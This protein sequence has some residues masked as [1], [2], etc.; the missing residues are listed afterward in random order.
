MKWCSSVVALL[1]MCWSLPAVAEGEYPKDL[2][3]DASLLPVP[4][5]VDDNVKILKE[6]LEESYSPALE[7]LL[8]IQY[9]ARHESSEA[10]KLCRNA[11]DSAVTMEPYYCMAMLA[12]YAG[13][14]KD[15]EDWLLQARE[16]AP[17]RA[18]TWLLEAN[19][20]SRGGDPAKVVAVIERGRKQAV[21]Y[22]AEYWDWELLRLLETM[23]DLEGALQVAGKLLHR[24]PSDPRIYHKTALLLWK[25]GDL[26]Q[27]VRMELACLARA[28]W[29]EE[30][31]TS[32]L[33]LL[34]AQGRLEEFVAYEQQ[35]IA[36]PQLRD[37]AARIRERSVRVH[38]NMFNRETEAV[39]ARYGLRNEARE[40]EKADPATAGAMLRELGNLARKHGR[41]ESALGWLKHAERL[42]P[43]DPEVRLSLGQALL[44]SG[45]YDAAVE[46]L[47][48]QSREGNPEACLVAAQALLAKSAPSTCIDVANRGLARRPDD[49]ELLRVLSTC[50]F[51]VGR[52]Q[53]ALEAIEK[54]LGTDPQDRQAQISRV[55]W[56]RPKDPTTAIDLLWQLYWQD[57]W[58]Y[59][60]CVKG[61]GWSRESGK[62]VLEARW[63]AACMGFMPPF[64]VDRRNEFIERIRFLESSDRNVKKLGLLSALCEKDG[65]YCEGRLGLTEQL[66]SGKVPEL[67]S[68][69]AAAD[70][71]APVVLEV[72]DSAAGKTE[73]L[74]LSAKGFEGLELKEKLKYYYLSRATIAALPLLYVQNHPLALPLTRLMEDLATGKK[75]KPRVK[76]AAGAYLK[77]LWA[78]HGP[79]DAATG[80]KIPP[81]ELSAEAVLEGMRALTAEGRKL[82]YLEGADEQEK[83]AGIEAFLFD[84]GVDAVLNSGPLAKDPVKDSASGIYARELSA[85]DISAAEAERPRPVNVRYDFDA[86]TVGAKPV[87]MNAAWKNGAYISNTV[88]FLRKA[89][90]FCQDQ[91]ESTAIEALAAYLERGDASDLQAWQAAARAFSSRGWQFGFTDVGRDP[92]L[93]TG[94]FEALVSIP[95]S[96]EG[97]L[98]RF[99]AAF[100]G[101]MPP[102]LKDQRAAAVG[103][104]ERTLLSGVF[105]ANTAC[106]KGTSVSE[107]GV[108]DSCTTILHGLPEGIM[109]AGAVDPE[110]VLPEY[111]L[112]VQKRA[113]PARQWFRYLV[114][115]FRAAIPR[116]LPP[117]REPVAVWRA[118]VSAEKEA[119]IAA[120]YFMS[121]PRLVQVGAFPARIHEQVLKAAYVMY[122]LACPDPGRAARFVGNA[123]ASAHAELCSSMLAPEGTGGSVNVLSRNGRSFVSITDLWGVREKLAAAGA[124]L[125]GRRASEAQGHKAKA[126]GNKEKPQAAS[127]AGGAV[128]TAPVQSAMYRA[129]TG[130]RVALVYPRLGLVKNAEG[131]VVDVVPALD[132]DFTAQQSRFSRLR[133]S[134]SEE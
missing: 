1:L 30:A 95:V 64:V 55:E 114:E 13:Q 48:G 124:E 78:N 129:G 69:G 74:R 134:L 47:E 132:E 38:E 31:A 57:P 15:A 33:D 17:E 56:Y 28:P 113:V 94:G 116:P 65:V 49:K 103:L 105:E 97:V 86:A 35:F 2:M 81:A 4:G 22:S 96:T 66:D 83:L 3:L 109:P 123:A 54:I 128:G 107:S 126:P 59:R 18:E 131:Q 72:F 37:F 63:M 85:S 67:E 14:Q 130:S 90:G 61:A 51:M 102:W 39:I 75:V 60:I 7:A 101:T 79:Y 125:V 53:D 36:S 44:D 29:F 12:Y 110:S 82:G 77:I 25:K 88:Y 27:A 121:D 91:R 9:L 42:L 117:Q 80:L 111:R 115:Y 119:Q 24:T 21:S 92:L 70:G 104:F 8:G 99:N 45:L 93:E 11:V 46:K 43:Q 41:M 23:G 34:E 100:A 112:M 76:K 68:E 118:Q 50:L 10:A 62:P 26:E 19:A 73:V 87:V 127:G 106:R 120:L 6:R 32:L 40:L 71:T 98:E 20:A 5:F 89:I 58:D 84:P 122:F 108:Q 52:D 16:R 133:D